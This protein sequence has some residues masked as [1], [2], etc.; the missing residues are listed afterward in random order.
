MK[1]IPDSV[2]AFRRAY[3]AQRIPAFY[4]GELHLLF[5]AAVLFGAVGWHL[6]KVSGASAR[7]LLAIPAT[8]VFGNWVEYFLHRYPLHR[9]YP[10]L[11]PIY[12]IHSLEHHRFYVY[13]AMEFESF[14]DF[15]MVLFPPWAPL[16]AIAFTSLVGAFV[17]TPL[18]SANCGHFFA[19]AGT[20]TLLLYE[21][22]HSLA[23]CADDGWAGKIPGIQGVRRHHR[24]H[25]DLELMSR[26]NFNITFPLFDWVYGT[27][28]GARLPLRSG[29]KAGRGVAAADGHAG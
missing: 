7:E 5:Q 12:Q 25:H 1:S 18:F 26:S 20:G 14:R 28:A 10:F 8:L 19:A 11:R 16:L 3:R 27:T 24:L 13:E 6:A 29:E 21:I 4:S 15:M 9:I 17:V 23:H 2:S 22:L